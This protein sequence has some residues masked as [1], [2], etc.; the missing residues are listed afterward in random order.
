[1]AL[2]I[3]DARGSLFG[4]LIDDAALLRPSTPTVEQAVEAYQRL[5]ATGHGWIVGRLV[6]PASRLEEL[7][8]VLVR[9]LTSGSAPM[10]IVAVFDGDTTSDAS[11]AAAVHTMLDPAARIDRVLL[12]PHNSDPIDGIADAVAAGNGVHHGVLSMVALQVGVPNDNRMEAI[13]AAGTEALRPA[14][15]WVDLRSSVVDPV[16]LFATIRACVRFSA[17]FTVLADQLPI[18]TQGTYP[19]GDCRYGAL[20]LLAAT[21]HAHSTESDGAAIL[22]DN[23]PRAYSID[24][25][26]LTRHGVGIRVRGSVGADRSPLVS[27]ATLNAPA[28]VAA[29]GTLDQ[30]P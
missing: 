25:G 21:L 12:P 22:S 13:A 27:L 5:R 3:P 29:L 15:G 28:A 24:F 1:M 11:I 7:A 6:V 30:V 10:P 2:L 18:V 14:G 8:G 19:T 4:G 16:A 23:D 9:T 26:G 17:P 20:N